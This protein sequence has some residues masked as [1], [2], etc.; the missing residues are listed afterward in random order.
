MIEEEDVECC[1]STCIPKDTYNGVIPRGGVSQEV[2]L[3]TFINAGSD[4]KLMI[5][6]FAGC[7]MVY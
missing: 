5:F 4:Q 6:S 1:P 3:Q 2:S 7:V